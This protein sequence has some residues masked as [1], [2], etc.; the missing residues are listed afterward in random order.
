METQKDCTSK[1]ST[2]LSSTQGKKKGK[3]KISGIDAYL[4]F[5]LA[6]ALAF[7]VCEEVRLWQT[8]GQEASELARGVF[9]MVTGELFGGILLYRFKIKKKEEETDV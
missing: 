9:T 7:A 1:Q 3:R 4:I 5:C 8:G 2:S 6:F